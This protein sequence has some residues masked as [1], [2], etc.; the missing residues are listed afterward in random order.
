MYLT[1]DHDRIDVALSVTSD[2]PGACI[3]KKTKKKR[4]QLRR[5]EKKKN[6]Q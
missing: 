2:K 3:E 5:M 6:S 1:L 4:L